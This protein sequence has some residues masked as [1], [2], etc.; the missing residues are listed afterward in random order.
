MAGLLS[1]GMYYGSKEALESMQIQKITQEG[2]TEKDGQ[3]IMTGEVE[4][5][6]GVKYRVEVNADSYNEKGGKGVGVGGGDF[7]TTYMHSVN[8]DGSGVTIKVD[9]Y[10][11]G[12]K[13]T[14]QELGPSGKVLSERASSIKEEP[15]NFV[16]EA[17]R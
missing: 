12:A 6:D 14:T 10:P 5:G 3:K 16:E 2:V 1:A 4:T 17:G 15:K 7:N 13:L 9:V 8:E 11:W